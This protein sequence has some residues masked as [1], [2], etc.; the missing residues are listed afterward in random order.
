M[1]R[2]GDKTPLRGTVLEIQR[3]STEDGPGIRSTVFMK[4]CPLRCLWCHNPESINPRPQVHWIGSRCIGCGLCVDACPE[5]ALSSTEAGIVIDR[6]LCRGC[7]TCAETCPS[8]ALELLGR[9]WE[10]EEL[11]EELVKD[12][13]Y[14]EKSGGGVTVS[15]GES[16]LQ[17]DFVSAL[18]R[19]LKERGI[20]TAVD[21]CGL[22]PPRAME[23]V[24][25]FADLVLF[26]VKEIDPDLHRRYTGSSNETILENLRQVASYVAEHLY[27]REL[28]VR[29]PVIPGTTDRE[30]N[31]EGIG[32]LLATLPS[33]SV[34]RWELCAF[35]N[36]CRD[37]YLR[38]EMHWEYD[39]TPLMTREQMERLASVARNSGID[40]SSVIWTGSVRMEEE[41]M[42]ED[43][44]PSAPRLVK[45]CGI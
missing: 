27:P 2:E 45:G 19:S 26:D 30:E 8:T 12:R 14:F 43:K 36:L 44:T 35:N 25:P 41:S 22:M 10:V 11:A 21:T 9:L 34:K 17:R 1:T 3:M 29:T 31:I 4:G 18:L 39:N 7:G 5:K 15:G 37:K 16:T 42:E 6:D 28:W 20:S 32:R 40:P 13:A 33:G 23:T 38:L 24:L